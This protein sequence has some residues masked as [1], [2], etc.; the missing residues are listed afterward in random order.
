MH[1]GG[2]IEQDAFRPHLVGFGVGQRGLEH[3]GG[4]A[5]AEIM[6]QRRG[7]GVARPLGVQPLPEGQ[8]IVDFSQASGQ[9]LHDVGGAERMGE[10]GV[11]GAGVGER[12]EPELADASQPLDFP[13]RQEPFDDGFVVG[14][15]GEQAVDRVAQDH[16]WGSWVDRSGRE[17]KGAVMVPGESGVFTGLAGAMSASEVSLDPQ[18]C[19]LPSNL[20]RAARMGR[21]RSWNHPRGW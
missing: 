20:G 19:R 4:R 2:V 16:G 7:Q 21:R 1:V 13:R 11:L 18:S 6:E 8:R 12:G 5:V 17:G 15:E 10:A 9:T 3:V 14:L